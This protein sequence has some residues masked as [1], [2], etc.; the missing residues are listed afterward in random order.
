MLQSTA[1]STTLC[2]KQKAKG[3]PGREVGKR[4]C[5]SMAKPGKEAGQGKEM[6][7]HFGRR[8]VT[9]LTTSSA[10]WWHDK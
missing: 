8:L 2:R 4:L 5:P 10:D 1:G 7:S 6:L 3:E 9:E